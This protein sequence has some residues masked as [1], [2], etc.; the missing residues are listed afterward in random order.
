MSKDEELNAKT[1]VEIASE[2]EAVENGAVNIMVTRLSFW[3]DSRAGGNSMRTGYEAVP[4]GMLRVR[5]PVEGLEEGQEI[6][7]QDMSKI[8]EQNLLNLFPVVEVFTKESES[9]F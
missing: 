9:D 4:F 1:V 7:C 6:T 8:L 3:M 2:G 5:V